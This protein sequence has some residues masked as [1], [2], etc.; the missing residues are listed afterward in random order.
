MTKFPVEIDQSS[1][2][3]HATD[4]AVSTLAAQIEATDMSILVTNA[5]SF[6][7]DRQ[8]VAI[9]NELVIIS[10]KTGNTLN[11]EARGA[12]GTVAAIQPISTAIS[13][14]FTAAHWNNITQTVAAMQEPLEFFRAPVES[15]DLTVP[16]GAPVLYSQYVVGTVATGAWATH[17][18]EIARWNG[19]DWDFIP[20][21]LGMLVY[22]RATD[23]Y[24]KFGEDGWEQN[25]G[26]AAADIAYDNA[27]SGATST[28]VQDALDEAFYKLSTPTFEVAFSITGGVYADEL[29]TVYDP[30]G[31]YVLPVGLTGSQGKCDASIPITTEWIISKEN[32]QIGKVIIIDN[33]VTFEFTTLTNF[34]VGDRLS[35]KS[36]GSVDFD[37]VTVTFKATR[38]PS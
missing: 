3:F 35:I 9:R 2:L 1:D 21:V 15:A 8:I 32:I 38:L 4:K 13:G 34:A 31:P 24:L 5:A 36:S 14:T 7:N 23:S 17:E 19:T 22:D 33:D 12:F 26:G 16:P 30:A 11:V 10:G 37:Y 18:D 29:L 28:N 6:A 20:G 25:G 27:A